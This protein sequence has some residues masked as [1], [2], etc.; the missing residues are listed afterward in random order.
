MEEVSRQAAQRFFALAEA[1]TQWEIT[2]TNH[3]NADTLYRIA[4]GRYEL[5]TITENDILQLEI[6]RLS[7]QTKSMNARTAVE[8]C[9]FELRNYLGIIDTLTITAVPT[10][11]IP[12]FAV[13]EALALDMA[14]ANN[15]GMTALERQAIESAGAVAQAKA[16]R[17]FQADFFL[18]FGLS[19]SADKLKPAYVYPERQ[20]V[21]SLGFQIPIFDWGRGKGR[22]KVAESNH[23]RMWV[24]IEQSR[25]AF[26]QN[27]LRLVRQF[28]QQAAKITIASKTNETA[29]RRH[30]VT[31]KLY[32][33]ERTT[34]LE[35]NA[36]ITEKDDA[37]RNY[38]ASIAGFWNLYY[39][40]RA[41]TGYD[42]RVDAVIG[43][44]FETLIK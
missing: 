24:E 42:F 9:L 43:E 27:I 12:V 34:T 44:D 2:R 35:L 18:E 29:R 41:L 28:N 36:A 23:E 33:Q 21:V 14:L 20:Q 17:G 13:D 11:D 5:G 30:E 3:A 25:V 37:Q 8:E 39:N 7:E 1:Q 19:Q 6:N 32:L 16:A 4:Q 15:A 40:L 22:V 26:R 31:Q 38:I 10:E